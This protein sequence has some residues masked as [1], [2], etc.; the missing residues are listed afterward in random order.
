MQ[1]ATPFVLHHEKPRMASAAVASLT[2]HVV[3]IG[4]LIVL[5]LAPHSTAIASLPEQ[6]NRSIVWLSERGPGGGG[7]GGGDHM[8]EPP[9]SA[10]LP[11]RDP[12]TVPVR[13]PSNAEPSPSPVNAAPQPDIAVREL[14]SSTVSLPGV[15]ATAPGLTAS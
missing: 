5:R 4:T 8:K 12:I 10:R 13:K 9:S 14:G 7:G 3:V 6:L 1:A 15:I 2:T 11:G